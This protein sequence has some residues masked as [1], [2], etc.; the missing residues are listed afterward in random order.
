MFARFNSFTSVHRLSSDKIERQE[1]H[2]AIFN[3]EVCKEN[4]YA[5][6]TFSDT[7]ILQMPGVTSF[8]WM[9]ILHNVITQ[10]D[11]PSHCSV[12]DTMQKIVGKDIPPSNKKQHNKRKENGNH[13]KDQKAPHI[14]AALVH[15][16]C[17]RGTTHIKFCRRAVITLMMSF[18]MRLKG[19]I[20]CSHQLQGLA[21]RAGAAQQSL[22]PPLRRNQ[23]QWS[24]CSLQK[25]K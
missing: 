5:L 4:L 20:P 2:S 13:H 18:S 15:T 23:Y 9:T 7:F 24:I 11:H 25:R 12:I 16:F 6:Y 21:I 22:A 19:K 14:A 8:W 1:H 10:R 3:L 17:S